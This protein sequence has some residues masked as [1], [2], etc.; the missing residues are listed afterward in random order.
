MRRSPAAAIAQSPTMVGALTVL[1]AILAVF[2]AY[3]ANNGLPF[4]P[5]YRISAEVPDAA[6]LVPGNEVRIGGVRVGAIEAIEPEQKANGNI[7]AK[8][9]LKLDTSAKPIPVN[10]TVSVRSRSA[11]GLKYLQIKKGNSSESFP[12]GSVVSLKH[13]KPETVD[14]DQV[15]NTFDEPT[16]RAIQINLREFGDALAGRG[17][18]LNAA[19]G[20]LRPLVTRLAP[21]ARNLS[22]RQTALGRFFDALGRTSAELAPVAETQA[23]VFVDMDTTFGALARVSRP[24][25]QDTISKGPE[26]LQV[27][28]DTAPEIQTFLHHSAALFADLRPGVNAFRVHGPAIASALETGAQVLPDSPKLNAELPPTA[29]ALQRFNDNSGARNG[30]SRLQQTN[31]LLGP[32]LDFVAPAQTV[33]NYATLLF[34]NVAS[35]V[36]LGDAHGKWQYFI[37]FEPPLDGPNGEGSP[38]S[39]PANGGSSDPGNFLHDNPYPNT[40]SPGQSPRECAAGNEKYKTGQQVIGNPPGNLGTTTEGQK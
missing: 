34:R 23:Q 21:V 30:L 26:T 17:A 11:L 25:I 38:S 14:I 29:R 10:S 16:R 5:T 12:E 20:E 19:I 31:S 24:F 15:L 22:S 35:T 28:T 13:A 2:L 36:S 32:T 3:N 8:L 33:C 9:D 27:A 39:A 37:N 18:D 1:I 4:V 6:S 40:A 7:A